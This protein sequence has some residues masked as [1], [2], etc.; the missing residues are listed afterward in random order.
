MPE[1]F[2]D[3]GLVGLLLGVLGK[4][5]HKIY[6][7][8]QQAIT[9]YQEKADATVDKVMGYLDKKSESDAKMV[10]TMDCIHKKICEIDNRLLYIE[11]GE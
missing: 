1:N 7:D 5:A 8:Q 11:G 10:E 4:V 3:Y 6:M 2:I 9:K